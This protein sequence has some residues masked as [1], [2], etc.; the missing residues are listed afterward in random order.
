MPRTFSGI[1]VCSPGPPSRS[2]AA[3]D[4]GLPRP[5]PRTARPQSR[6]LRAP[7]PGDPDPSP[8]ARTGKGPRLRNGEGGRL[9]PRLRSQPRRRRRRW[10][11]PP[12]GPLSLTRGGRRSHRE[13]G[14]RRSLLTQRRGRGGECPGAHASAAPRSPRTQPPR[15]AQPPPPARWLPPSRPRPPRRP[16]RPARP[17]ARGRPGGPAAR[18]AAASGAAA[19]GRRRAGAWILPP[20]PMK[21]EQ[22]GRTQ[23]VPRAAGLPRL[24]VCKGTLGNHTG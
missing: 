19:G 12:A 22:G 20:G 23:G 6:L 14:A 24:R 18:W 8:P 1:Q 13:A 11:G 4:P 2:G 21:S 15:R 5:P 7:I 10:R 3:L 17:P 16:L 9:A